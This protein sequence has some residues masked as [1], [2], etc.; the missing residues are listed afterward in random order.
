M[1]QVDYSPS[2]A[3]LL[4]GPSARGKRRLPPD[5]DVGDVVAQL[6]RALHT[7][8]CRELG[9]AVAQ[10]RFGSFADLHADRYV[11]FLDPDGLLARHPGHEELRRLLQAVQRRG[12]AVG[13]TL[14]TPRT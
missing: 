10:Q 6:K 14:S 9:P 8:A 1:Q 4:T 5:A 13:V 11:L 2:P 12:P 3:A 7:I